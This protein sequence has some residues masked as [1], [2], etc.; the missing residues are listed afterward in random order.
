[1]LGKP[2][3]KM[4]SKQAIKLEATRDKFLSSSWKLFS[5]SLFLALGIWSIQPELHWFWDS[6]NY[7]LPYASTNI[8]PEVPSRILSYYAAET[9]YYIYSTI[10]LFWE[11]RTKDRGQMFVHHIF[12]TFLLVSSWVGGTTK[13][14]VPIMLLHDIADPPLEFAKMCTYAGWEVVHN[15]I[16]IFIF[17]SNSRIV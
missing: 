15:L 12:T 5:Y 10:A 8:S 4:A 7:H 6:Y 3:A 2:L 11:P 16:Y 13:F 9:G 14:G 17:P 1:M